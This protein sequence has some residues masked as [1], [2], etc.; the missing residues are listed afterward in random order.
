MDLDQWV[1]FLVVMDVHNMVIV[2]LGDSMFEG[3]ADLDGSFGGFN[4]VVGIDVL[5]DGLA[6]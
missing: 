3:H 6:G 4:L 5:E 1:R 2:L